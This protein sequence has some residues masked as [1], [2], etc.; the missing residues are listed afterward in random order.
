M[1]RVIRVRAVIYH[2]GRYL[3]VRHA[4]DSP[5][6]FPGGKLEDAESL[7]D[8]LVRELQEELG[9]TADIGRLLYMQQLFRGEEESLEC[10]FEVK[11]G[12]EFTDLDLAGTSHGLSE[13]AEQ[14][15]ID[16]SIESVL[17]S[18]LRDLPA[19]GMFKQWPQIFVERI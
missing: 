8:G 15:F 17:P 6:V 7:Q 4:H 1:V 11:N 3:F 19:D 12:Q 14:A 2:D 13:I 16:P 9:V 10:F 5:W 18:F